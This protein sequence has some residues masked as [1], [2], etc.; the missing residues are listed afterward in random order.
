MSGLKFR[1]ESFAFDVKEEGL[2][3][4]KSPEQ[5]PYLGRVFVIVAD[6]EGRSKAIGQMGYGGAGSTGIDAGWGLPG[7]PTRLVLVRATQV[8]RVEIPVRL[9]GI[10]F[11]P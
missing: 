1:E 10:V 6:D 5:Q 11:P 9:R 2:K 7:R 8:E 4:W 3:G